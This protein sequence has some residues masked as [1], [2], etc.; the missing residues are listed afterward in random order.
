MFNW[1]AIK[2]KILGQVD[3]ATQY[4]LEATAR[5][6]AN[7]IEAEDVIPRMTGR[8]EN[9]TIDVLDY[10]RSKKGEVKI[11]SP[12]PYARRWYF[13]AE[14]AHFHREPWEGGEGNP[15]ARD[16]WFEPWETSNRI[17][18]VFAYYLDRYMRGSK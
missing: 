15:N 8:M 5:Q 17:P 9:L 12:G 18:E 4:A 2:R 13:N 3:E 7:E 10:S 14:G 16:H 11:T 6:I 1:Q